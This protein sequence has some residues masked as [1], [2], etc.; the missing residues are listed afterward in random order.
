MRNINVYCGWHRDTIVKIK[1]IIVGEVVFEIPCL[2]CDGTG[3]WNYFPEERP[4]HSCV[5]CKGTGKQ[6]VGI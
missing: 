3:I 1:P 2:E 4:T 6:Y 5:V